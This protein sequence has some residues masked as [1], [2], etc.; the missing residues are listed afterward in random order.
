MA[1]MAMQDDPRVLE[2]WLIGY[3]ASECA[4]E[5]GLDPILVADAFEALDLGY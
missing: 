4:D 3:S 2:A 1:T 5:L